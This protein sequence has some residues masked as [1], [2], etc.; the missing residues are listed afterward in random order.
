MYKNHNIIRSDL[1]KNNFIPDV[2]LFYHKVILLNWTYRCF[3]ILFFATNIADKTI[4]KDV[5]VCHIR[6]LKILGPKDKINTFQ[7]MLDH[8]WWLFIFILIFFI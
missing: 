5:I 3:H 6:K 1:I 2:Y 7:E 8:L 4:T